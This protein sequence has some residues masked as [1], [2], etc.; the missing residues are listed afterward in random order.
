M[1]PGDFHERVDESPTQS[2]SLGVGPTLKP[3]FVSG[4]GPFEN[5][6]LVQRKPPI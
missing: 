4:H 6:L 5:D 3:F 1:A 2:L